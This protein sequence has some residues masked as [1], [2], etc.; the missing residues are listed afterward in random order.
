[1]SLFLEK[2]HLVHFKNYENRLLH[3]SEGVNCI[4]GRN[5]SGKTNL[6]DAIHYLCLTKSAFSGSDFDNIKNGE[7]TATCTGIFREG[8]DRQTIIQCI[9]DGTNRKKTVKKNKEPYARL[10]E[11]IGQFPVVMIEPDD[12]DLVRGS[13]EGRRRFFDS[14]ICQYNTEYLKHLLAYN[15]L[16][17]Q[18]NNLLKQFAERQYA[19]L[20]LLEAYDQKLLQH[21]KEIYRTRKAFIMEYKS[22]FESHYSRLTEQAETVTVSYQ[23][24]W[25][26]IDFE[27]KFTQNRHK[28]LAAQRTLTGIHK[29]DYEFIINDMSLKKTGSQGQKKSFVIALKTANFIKLSEQ[30]YT[31]PLMLLD[32]I[33]DKLDEHRIRQLVKLV[34]G[35]SFGQVFITDARPDRSKYIFEAGGLP[36]NIIDIEEIA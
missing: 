5:G 29:D 11:H 30:K 12:T 20:T 9:L 1:M 36:V 28:D 35:S 15:R 16:L 2:I 31:R 6:L 19:D 17:L 34:N 10:S 8:K 14:V 32:D 21:G 25:Q 7:P 26:Q 3:F 13:S 22:L 27:K 24:D 18:R 23:S 4:T 33:F